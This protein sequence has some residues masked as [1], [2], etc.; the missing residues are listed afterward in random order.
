MRSA[1]RLRLA[2]PLAIA[3]AVI[4]PR[5]SAQGDQPPDDQRCTAP[6]DFVTQ[7]IC[8]TPA[9]D[10]LDHMLRSTYEAL[11]SDS[12]PPV[13]SRPKAVVPENRPSFP[14]ARSRTV[15]SVRQLPARYLSRSVTGQ[16]PPIR[17]CLPTLSKPPDPLTLRITLPI[18]PFE[19]LI[20]V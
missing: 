11:I 17:P 1:A 7:A 6:A 10:E 5:A 3:M 18:L 13:S 19:V 12:S 16:N 8:T 20:I 15:R 14:L 2:V 9:L 4:A